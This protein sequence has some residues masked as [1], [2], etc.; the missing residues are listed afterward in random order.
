MA[1]QPAAEPQG[2]EPRRH[3]AH[4]REAAGEGQ[5]SRERPGRRRAHAREAAGEGKAR[6]DPG[7]AGLPGRL[8]S[9][10]PPLRKPPNV[11]GARFA[12]Q[13]RQAPPALDLRRPTP[14]SSLSFPDQSVS[15]E[16]A[17]DDFVMKAGR[18]DCDELNT[19]TLPNVPVFSAP[20]GRPLQ[21][22]C[23]FSTATITASSNFSIFGASNSR[24]SGG[25][26]CLHS[27]EY[28]E[29]S[30]DPSL[31]HRPIRR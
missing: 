4:A 22:S 11:P 10:S 5:A 1:G 21:R 12:L 23:A 18:R 19:L 28:T 24:S 20:R 30:P 25:P 7:G 15:C 13:H 27:D 14:T 16:P 3:R 29:P 6:R 17:A 31:A 9:G 2:Q 8:S 26:T